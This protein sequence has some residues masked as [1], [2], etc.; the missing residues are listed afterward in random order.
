MKTKVVIPLANGKFSAWFEVDSP[1]GT[2]TRNHIVASDGNTV[3]MEVD[4][5][6]GTIDINSVITIN[7]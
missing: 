4:Y 6:L 3:E 2:F 5:P 7:S 1:D